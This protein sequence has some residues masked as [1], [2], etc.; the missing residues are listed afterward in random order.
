MSLYVEGCVYVLKLQG[1]LTEELSFRSCIIAVSL[2]GH[3]SP[4]WIVFG[5][6]LWFGLGESFS[7]VQLAND[8]P[9]F[10]MLLRCSVSLAAPAAPPSQQLP[11]PVRAKL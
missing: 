9:T 1:P 7:C 4:K 6:P 11:V 10:T 5:T 3:L 8:Q 2:I